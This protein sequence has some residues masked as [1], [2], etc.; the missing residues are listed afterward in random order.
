M[1]DA[2]NTKWKYRRM[3]VLAHTLQL[4]GQAIAKEEEEEENTKFT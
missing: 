3:P 4:D 1:E 2:V